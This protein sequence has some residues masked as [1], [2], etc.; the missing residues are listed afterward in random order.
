[1]ERDMVSKVMKQ[2][3]RKGGKRRMAGLTAEQRK[4]L[5]RKAGIA[6]GKARSEKVRQ[7]VKQ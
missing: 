6:S 3:G 2:M 5:A 4:E 1:M 7:K